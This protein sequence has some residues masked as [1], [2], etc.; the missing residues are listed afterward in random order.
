MNK[1]QL[2]FLIR[3]AEKAIE[4]KERDIFKYQKN[5]AEFIYEEI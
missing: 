2:N 3:L 4:N 5:L 1:N